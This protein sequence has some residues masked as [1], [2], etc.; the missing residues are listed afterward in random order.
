MKTFVGNVNSSLDEPTCEKSVEISLWEESFEIMAQFARKIKWY[1][2]V[3]VALA[4]IFVW[5]NWQELGLG[6]TTAITVSYL[7]ILT[8]LFLLVLGLLSSFFRTAFF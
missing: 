1:Y 8:I 4:M 3:I 2:P 5:N 7:L 6:E